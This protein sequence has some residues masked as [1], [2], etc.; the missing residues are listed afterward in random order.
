MNYPKYPDLPIATGE[1]LDRLG[2]ERDV[3]RIKYPFLAESD[4]SYRK[5]ILIATK[6][7]PDLQPKENHL[8]K[9]ALKNNNFRVMIV[10]ITALALVIYNAVNLTVVLSHLVIGGAASVS[11]LTWLKGRY[12]VD[13]SQRNQDLANEIKLLKELTKYLESNIEFCASCKNPQPDCCC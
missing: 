11:L 10:W 6:Y 4:K 2:L 9:R 7:R 5:R 3:K 13:E 8:T 12:A 1:A